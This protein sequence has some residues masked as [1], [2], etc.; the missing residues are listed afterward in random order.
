MFLCMERLFLLT[1]PLPPRTEG[2]LWLFAGGRLGLKAE[3]W[4]SDKASSLQALTGNGAMAEALVGWLGQQ[5]G[6][7]GLG[8]GWRPHRD[9]E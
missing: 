6:R 9:T 1:S 3:S 4:P 2:S 8:A 7:A 5:L